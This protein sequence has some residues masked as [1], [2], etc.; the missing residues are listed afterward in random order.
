MEDET[1][2]GFNKRI[3]LENRTKQK[4]HSSSRPPRHLV[5]VLPEAGKK[6]ICGTISRRSR[7]RL[8]GVLVVCILWKPDRFRDPPNKCALPVRF[9]GKC[10]CGKCTCYPPGDPRVYGKTCECDGRR[11]EGLDGMVCGGKRFSQL[12]G[13]LCLPF[14]P[15]IFFFFFNKRKLC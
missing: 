12:R 14:L 7:N 8:H 11:C 3:R 4:R 9:A 10:E 2:R 5:L 6:I 1:P 13:Q 15:C